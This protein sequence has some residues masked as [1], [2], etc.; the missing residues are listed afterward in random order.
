[1]SVMKTLM[2]NYQI[3]AEELVTGGLW[4]YSIPDSQFLSYVPNINVCVNDVKPPT[5]TLRKESLQFNIRKYGAVYEVSTTDAFPS[6]V[7]LASN[8]EELINEYL[9]VTEEL[10]VGVLNSLTAPIILGSKK[11]LERLFVASDDDSYK[12]FQLNHFIERKG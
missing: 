8:L 7:L 9:D 3:E 5:E 2:P 4:F 12:V 10:Y 11:S 6:S 1:M